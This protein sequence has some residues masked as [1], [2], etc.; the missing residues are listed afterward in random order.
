[1]SHE[2]TWFWEML[3]DGVSKC[4]TAVLLYNDF[5]N[6]KIIVDQYTQNEPLYLTYNSPDEVSNKKY[7][8]FVNRAINE[9]GKLNINRKIIIGERDKAIEREQA[10]TIERDKAIEREQARTI[11]RDKAI[12]REQART[13][14]RDKAIEREQ[15]R[16]IERD[17][18]I[19]REQER[20][21][22]RDKAIESKEKL[23]VY[24]F[25]F[26]GIAFFV[27]FIMIIFFLCQKFCPKVL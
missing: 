21:I 10:R 22:E 4:K 26:G 11:E 12:K 9:I 8:N 23:E 7:S 6:V 3:K 13:I 2:Y 15:A 5:K 1:M 25:I 18:A 24:F 16:T 19:E 14:E 17:K 27:F 20:T